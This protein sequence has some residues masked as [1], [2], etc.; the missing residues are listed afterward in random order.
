[1][2]IVYGGKW[3]MTMFSWQDIPIP[4]YS[5]TFECNQIPPNGQDV[6]RYCNAEA[7]K[8]MEQI[9][10]TYDPA[11]QQALFDR[12]VRMILADVPTIVLDVY[13]VGF[14]HNKNLAGFDPGA[15]TPFDNL[16]NVDI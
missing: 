7:D 9:K 10:G 2:G 8:L 3:D 15:F 14:A 16:R 11:K 5:N 12:V 1:A 13:D 6:T 4:D